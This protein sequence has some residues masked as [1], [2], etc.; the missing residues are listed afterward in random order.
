MS[1]KSASVILLVLL[2]SGFS[3]QAQT[4]IRDNNH[5]YEVAELGIIKLEL[6]AQTSGIALGKLTVPKFEN[7][8]P[9]DLYQQ[10]M[11]ALVLLR[12]LQQKS[13]VAVLA[14]V[15]PLT[16]AVVYDDSFD[17][18]EY[19][20]LGLDVLLEQQSLER[21][22]GPESL[23]G[24]STNDNYGRLWYLK[25][26]L[27]ELN[28]PPDSRSVQTQLAFIK[29]SLDNLAKHKS[30]NSA[31][32]VTQLFEQKSYRDVML[33]AYQNLHLLGRLQR[34]LNVKPVA[35]GSIATGARELIDIFEITRSTIGDLYRTRISLGL[36]DPGSVAAETEDS[37]VDDI[38]QSMREI[39]A[40]LVA[41]TGSP[42][43]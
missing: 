6:L 39:Q 22:L 14:R 34:V 32:V 42:I 10:T 36:P 43:L 8:R 18:L 3:A 26:L 4:L 12:Q 37:S 1:V 31:G 25:Q 24:K 7:K 35:P 19:I 29:I 28:S 2:A 17:M 5:I 13:S 16:R 11:A 20:N 41:M 38:Y 15:A 9:T 40:Q 33:V 27:V 30:L 23:F 21:P